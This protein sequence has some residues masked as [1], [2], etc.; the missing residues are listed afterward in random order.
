VPVKAGFYFP[1]CCMALEWSEIFMIKSGLAVLTALLSYTMVDIMIWQRI[2][3]S[4]N[5]NKF[6]YLYHPGW[7]AMLGGEIVLGALLL[8]PN[9]RA[10]LF[11]VVALISMALCGMEDILYYWLDG[12]AIPYYLPWLDRNPWIL[13]KPV[14][15][16]NLLLSVSIWVGVC[17][18]FF[19][20]ACRREWH[21]WPR[22]R[23]LPEPITFEI[24]APRPAREMPF[25]MDSSDQQ[26]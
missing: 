23:A 19:I 18:F 15:S 11:Y 3:E 1:Y 6:A 2:F 21:R 22:P 12:R 10:V 9:W 14:T 5:L 13:F 17:A 16:S 8:I 7:I 20:L 24:P 26:V 25:R 4:H